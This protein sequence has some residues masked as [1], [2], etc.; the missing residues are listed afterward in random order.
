VSVQQ[1]RK[2]QER[3]SQANRRWDKEAITNSLKKLLLKKGRLTQI[4]INEA[5][6][7][8]CSEA[9]VNHFGSLDAAYAAAGYKPEPRLPFGMNGKFWSKKAASTGLQKLHAA[10]GYISN[11]L[12]DRFSGLP[13]QALIRCRFGSISEAMSRQDC[14]LFPIAKRSDARGS[15]EKQPDVTK[16]IKVFAGLTQ[17]LPAHYVNYRN[18]TATLLRIWSIAMKMRLAPTITPNGLAR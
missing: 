5:E 16:F 17:S 11:R 12:I 14:L 9:V 6:D 7:G 13:S 4:L 1:F 8:P 2:A 3:L 15:D 10:H 18:G